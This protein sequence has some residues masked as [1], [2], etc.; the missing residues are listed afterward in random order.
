VPCYGFWVLGEKRALQRT[1]WP[2]EEGL[3]QESRFG[4]F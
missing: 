1:R 2:L 3:L 4:A